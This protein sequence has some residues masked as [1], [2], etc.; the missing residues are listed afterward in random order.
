MPLAMFPA[1]PVAEK[2]PPAML[3]AWLNLSQRE[4]AREFVIV[5]ASAI[6]IITEESASVLIC[7]FS[8]LQ[9]PGGRHV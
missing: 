5:R 6:A 1:M 8:R 2:A 4:N 3:D 9:D 7:L